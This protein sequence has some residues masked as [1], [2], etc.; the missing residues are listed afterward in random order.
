MRQLR[1][2][3]IFNIF[4]DGRWHRYQTNMSSKLAVRIF[5]KANTTSAINLKFGQSRQATRW[6]LSF[7]KSWFSLLR[8]SN[9]K[10]KIHSITHRPYKTRTSRFWSRELVKC[11]F[12]LPKKKKHLNRRL[13]FYWLIT[14]VSYNYWPCFLNSKYYIVCAVVHTRRSECNRTENENHKLKN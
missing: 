1:Q 11:I 10:L 12:S 9:M 2:Q 14:G 5:F 8:Y 6:L 3:L 7:S 4:I 13:P